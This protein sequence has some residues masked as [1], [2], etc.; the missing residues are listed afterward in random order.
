MNNCISKRKLFD[1]YHAELEQDEMDIIDVHLNDCK[2]CKSVLSQIENEVDLMKESFYTLN[3]EITEIPEFII[4]KK[5]ILNKY[6][7]RK[8][9]SWAASICLLVTVSTIVTHKIIDNQRPVN[10]Y[11]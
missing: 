10:D 5:Y 3:P 7:K 9:L 2:S 11:E 1:Y 6:S 8:I 4:K